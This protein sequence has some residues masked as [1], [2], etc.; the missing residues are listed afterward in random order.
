MK[1]LSS[2]LAVLLLLS[3]CVNVPVIAQ[4]EEEEIEKDFM[5]AALFFGGSLPMGGLSDWG[6]TSDSVQYQ[7][8]T[9]MGFN[10]GI[11]VGYFLTANM[12]LGF[13]ITA[14]QYTID[15]DVPNAADLPLIESRHHR[16]YS[17]SAYLKYYFAGESALVPYVKG[18]AGL[19]IVKYTTRVFDTNEGGF[20]YRELSYDP[21]FAFGA[22]AG[23][24]YYTHDYGGLFLEVNYHH[25]LTSEV[26]SDYGNAGPYVFGETASTLDFHAGI[27]VFFGSDE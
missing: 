10:F 20:E 2:V 23:L 6:L 8:G 4:D 1:K 25:G 18:H 21:G 22:G 17:P 16:I 19:D 12:V 3:V 27:K 24:F 15:P 11:E 14:S 9:E 7:L 5:E 13:N 26:K